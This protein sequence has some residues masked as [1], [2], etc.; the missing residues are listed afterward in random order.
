M[1]II[2][3]L[4]IKDL[5]LLIDMKIKRNNKKIYIRPRYPNIVKITTPIFLAK[6]KLEEIL[7]KDYEFIKKIVL[8]A[9]NEITSNTIHLFGKE[10]K[11]QIETSSSKNSVEIHENTIYIYATRCGEIP[12]QDIIN[13]FYMVNLEKFVEKELDEAK[14][15]LAINFNITVK[16]KNVKTY[17]GQCIP[18]RRIVTFSTKLAKYQPI[19]I[20]SVIY[21]ELAHFYY[22]NHNKEFYSLLEKVF[23]G[24]LKLQKELKRIKFLDIY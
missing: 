13:K 19:Y 12:T 14:N 11:L 23:P 17:F 9:P 16:Y 3:N 8:S 21:H 4:K 18:K 22:I 5:D 7:I 2:L 6:S 24:Y 1:I 15:K 10:F 20:K